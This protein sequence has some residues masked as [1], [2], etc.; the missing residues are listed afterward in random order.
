[1]VGRDI[2]TRRA[3]SVK[4]QP[5]CAQAIRGAS[6]E[7]TITSPARPILIA[8]GPRMV[9]L[10]PALPVVASAGASVS[11]GVSGR[12]SWGLPKNVVVH[13]VMRLKIDSDLD[14]QGRRI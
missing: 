7:T 3:S 5:R 10:P 8:A 6:G 1:M 9:T 14:E 11:E 13:V 2:P 4:L 12:H